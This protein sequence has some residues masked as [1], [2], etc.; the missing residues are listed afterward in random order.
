M[1][2]LSNALKFTFKGCVTLGAKNHPENPQKLS[3]WVED[4]G[5]GMKNEKL[6]DLCKMFGRN[7]D[8]TYTRGMGLGL[9]IANE[10]SSRL[11]KG[12]RSLTLESVLG[13]GS[14]F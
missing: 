13:E 2:L 10:L 7:E 3:F 6:E 11:N 5:I 9:T 14:K 12:D 1:G 8:K 4:T